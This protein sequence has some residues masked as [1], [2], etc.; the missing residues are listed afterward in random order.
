M[1]ADAKGLFWN[2]IEIKKASA[3]AKAKR[4]PPERVWESPDYLPGL[5]VA[6]EFPAR[7]M[8]VEDW[9]NKDDTILL[10]C[11]VYGNYFLIGFKSY[12]TGRVDWMEFCTGKVEDAEQ[13][14]ILFK[15]FDP[16]RLQAILDNC[17]TCG[18]NS[19]FYDLTVIALALAG[20]STMSIKRASDMM[21]Q[22]GIRPWDVLKAYKVK[23]LKCDHIDLIEVA[24][25]SRSL[26][27][28]GASLHVPY[29]QDLPFAPSTRLS[30]DQI[31][32]VRW[33]CVGKDLTTT[34]YLRH[35]VDDQIKLREALSH[36]NSIDLRSKSDAQI[37]EAIIGKHVSEFNG[38]KAKK[39]SQWPEG[40][41][42]WY[43]P[44]AYMKFESE[45]MQQAYKVVCETPLIVNEHGRIP[46]PA[47]LKALKITIGG[48]TYRMGI[49]GLHSSEQNVSHY[50]DDEWVLKDI[51]GTSYYPRI[52]INQGLYPAHLGSNFTRVFKAIVDQR[53]AA[54]RAGRKAEA[55]TLK[56]TINGTFGKL[57]SPH[58]IF[59]APD[60]MLQTTLTG[61]LSL[62]LFIETVERHGMHAVS[63]NTD[64]VV[65]KCRRKDV[66]LLYRLIE[67]W[68][69]ATD[70]EMEDVEYRSLH[71]RDVNSYIS[72][73][74]DGSVKTKG[75]F[76]NPW[77]DPK[78][79]SFICHK[80]PTTT[81][82]LDALEDYL[83]SGAPYQDRI[84]ACK[85]VRK[86]LSA[87]HV[88]GG[89]VTN[90]IFLGK[91]IRWYYS[92]GANTEIVYAKSGNLV[93]R[94]EGAVPCMD[95]P[96]T[97]PEDIDYD[98]YIREVESLLTDVGVPVAIAG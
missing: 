4:T 12:L 43:R 98:W 63:A 36:T 81:I 8:T 35:N 58:S 7:T 88:N 97:L 82:C 11:E 67:D 23:Q 13:N 93:P 86:F 6:Q 90:G 89:A 29:L 20:H 21:I 9:Y 84:R 26:K 74:P 56:I 92:T 37:A 48:S 28:Y 73:K 34:G 33:Y 94:S 38:V 55:D 91:E 41:V 76:S 19:K 85:D 95:L 24:P 65:V 10:D 51:D 5:D 30:P 80:A 1:R 77:N 64:G 72:I 27:A 52:I 39:P 47:E 57:G 96:A 69:N 25:L 68:Q 42:F 54:K 45:V 49:G 60:M 61:Q 71:S 87:R 62:L 50:S 18:F 2:A 46:L 31:D 53:V 44:Q 16:V 32:I 70:I 15:P 78:L 75:A 79:A 83:V 14:W 40:H 17:R 22:E 3:A 66:D 59:Y